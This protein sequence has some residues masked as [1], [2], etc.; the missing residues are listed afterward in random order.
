MDAWTVGLSTHVR[1]VIEGY[2][3]EN[4]EQVVQ[5][6]GRGE[7]YTTGCTGSIPGLGK[8]GIYELRRWCGLLPHAT[9]KP[10]DIPELTALE[11]AVVFLESRGYTVT[12]TG[13]MD[14]LI[15]KAGL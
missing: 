11:W 8:K 7:I 14:E 2:G 6:F 1:N 4:K 13:T 9:I 15:K 5:A 12:Y 10:K 3:F